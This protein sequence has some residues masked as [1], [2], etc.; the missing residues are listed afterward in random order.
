MISLPPGIIILVGA[1][2]LPLLPR[3]AQAIGALALPAL[4]LAQLLFLSQGVFPGIELAGLSLL[5]VRVDPLSLAFGYIFH[6]AAFIAALYALHV[7]DTIQHV[8]AML[9]VGSAIGVTTTLCLVLFF[10]PAPILQLVAP[11]LG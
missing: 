5:Q 1:L 4:S 3:S 7:R 6:I 2:A 11:L 10:Y 9:Y 8:T